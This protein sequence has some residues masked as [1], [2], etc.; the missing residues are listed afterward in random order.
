MSRKTVAEKFHEDVYDITVTGRH[1]LVTDAMEQYAIEKISGIDRFSNRLISVNVTM[2][3]QKIEH[4][5]DITMKVDHITIRSS[6]VTDNMYAS[7]DKAVD[8]L[9]AQLR[10]YKGRIR[11]HQ[12]KSISSIDMNVKVVAPQDELDIVNDEIDS[13]A[14]V[15]LINNYVPHAIVSQETRPLK[16]LNYNEAIMKVELSGDNFLVFCAEEDQKLKVIYR[17][18]SGHF[19]IIEPEK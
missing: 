3:I 13:E 5:V 9:K 12:S 18:N 6:A 11:E 19:G 16:T 14:N 1:V 4:K 2:D 17:R 15:S 10:K 8:R 7:I